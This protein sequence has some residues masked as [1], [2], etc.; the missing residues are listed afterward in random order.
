MKKYIVCCDEGY[1]PTVDVYDTLE[2]AKKE[3]DEDGNYERRDNRIFLC[4]I[5]EEK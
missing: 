2:E 4:E 5:L 1:Y 3:Y